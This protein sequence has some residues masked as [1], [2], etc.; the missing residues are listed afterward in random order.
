[1]VDRT[2]VLLRVRQIVLK[3]VQHIGKTNIYRKD[4]KLI[5]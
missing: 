1:M 3:E 2:G 4:K 5:A